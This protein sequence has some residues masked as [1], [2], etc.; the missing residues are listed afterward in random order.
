MVSLFLLNTPE[1]RAVAL[2]MVVS[3]VR[4]LAAGVFQAALDPVAVAAIGPPRSR[5]GARSVVLLPHEGADESIPGSLR[6]GH[7]SAVVLALGATDDCIFLVESAEVPPSR[8]ENQ[9]SAVPSVASRARE[10]PAGSTFLSA[11]PR[12]LQPLAETLFNA[13][14]ENWTGR[15]VKRGRRWVASP[16]NFW[17]VT[18]Q[19]RDGSL[20]I[21]VRGTPEHFQHVHGR[22]SVVSDRGSYSRFKIHATNQIPDAVAIIR[23]ASRRIR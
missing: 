20:A 16:D 22:I 8:L 6:F 3:D 18:P 13:V 2:Q 10:L 11:T 15:L 12:H 23:H 21:T 7:E 1:A 19:P 5:V 17:T 9:Q 14:S 4:K